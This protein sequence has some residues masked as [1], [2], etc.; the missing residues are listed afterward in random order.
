MSES[1]ISCDHKHIA[2]RIYCKDKGRDETRISKPMYSDA[3]NSESYKVVSKY[4]SNS[5]LI[6]AMW[7]RY[8]GVE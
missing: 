5:S 6:L 7:D 8:L 3:I 1:T 2:F 4:R